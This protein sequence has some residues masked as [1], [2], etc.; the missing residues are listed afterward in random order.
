MIHV[1]L[2]VSAVAL[3]LLVAACAPLE[4]RK[5]GGDAAARERDLDECRDRA[6]S[7]AQQEAPL[8]GQPRPP[9]V[10]F[11]TRGRVVTGHSGRYDT[12]RALLENDINRRCMTGRGYQLE[13]AKTP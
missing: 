7:Q 8:F 6:R 3:S 4:W 10:G 5:D 2:R 9:D 11:D 12:E 1:Y 13:P